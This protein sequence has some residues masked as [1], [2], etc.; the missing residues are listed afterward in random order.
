M[1][2][3]YKD[4]FKNLRAMQ[5]QLWEESAARFP[6]FALPTDLTVWQR[7][8]LEN[9]SA[10]AEK[11]IQQ[12]LD[13]Q[14]EWL[15]QWSGRAAD[16]K[17]KPKSFADLNAE[18]RNTMQRWLDYQNQLWDQWVRILGG[19]SSADTTLPNLSDWQK[20]VE[21]SVQ[22]QMALLQD[23]SE[24]TDFG[25]LT[26]REMGKLSD[27]IAKSMQKSVETQQ[28]FWTQW[29]KALGG[30]AGASAGEAQ[31]TGQARPRQQRKSA[32]AAESAPKQE[33]GSDND[34]KRIAGIGP[35]LEK[36]L[37]EQGIF[38]VSQIA[39]LSDEDIESL[40]QKIVRF[41]G[42]IKREKWV[43]QAQ[44]LASGK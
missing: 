40:E 38:S 10:W 26:T 15:D 13:L 28:Q 1:F 3:T 24:M 37:N 33:A 42:R 34:L 29:F 11:A 9:V 19:S 18:A 12:S 43:E 35:A 32:P 6:E 17:L 16:K 39:N 20:T 14:R 5:D 4:I 7:Q 27:Q 23:W 31:R 2:K 22:K 25:K 21:D 30:A 41:P 44:A 36:K 8:T